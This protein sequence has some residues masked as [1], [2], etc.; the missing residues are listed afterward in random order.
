[1]PGSAVIN[2]QTSYGA[3]FI[4]M[5]VNHMLFGLEIVQAWLYYWKYWK[6]DRKVF[7]IFVAFLLG[8]D[9]ATTIM[10]TYGVYWHLVLNFGNVK[11]LQ[12]S[13]SAMSFLPVFSS[14]TSSAAQL[15]FVRRA[16]LLSQSIICPLIAV[17]LILGGNFFCF[18]NTIRA[19]TTNKY[20][21]STL[22][23]C[24]WIG[25]TVLADIVISGTICWTLYRKRTG[26][27]STD[28]MILSLMV[29][30]INSVLLMSALGIALTITFAVAPTN[31]IW[32]ALYW[33][34]SKCYIN[35]LLAML[36]TRDYIRE[37]SA[38]D[39]DMAMIQ[40]ESTSEAY[41]PQSKQPRVTVTVHRSTASNLASHGPNSTTNKG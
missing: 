34:T 18:I 4:G 38:T 9:T 19:V 25:A 41:G 1:M 12:Q 17:P 32:E 29:Y 7:K 31:M 27:A 5:L 8:M 10:I 6:R 28:S 14:I 36:N 2:I 21:T 3:A 16:Y 30:T 26:F 22:L 15:Y 24:L 23:P 39:N 13:V 11:S 33:V 20:P 40:F 37:R 35:S